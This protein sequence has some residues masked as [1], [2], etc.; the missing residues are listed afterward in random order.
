M[1]KAW[2]CA[3]MVGFGAGNARADKQLEG[4]QIHHGFALEVRLASRL[5][6]FSS[7][8][9]ALSIGA[10][11]GGIFA[12]Y[13]ISRVIFGLGFDISRVATGASGGGGADTS[14]A[15]TAFHF[16]P[17]VQVA[18][19]RSALKRVEMFG[20]FD[21]GF[22][23]TIHEQKPSVP[24]PDTS[25]FLL[26]YQVGP[27]VRYWP[28][29]QFAVSG[30]AGV[31]GDFSWVSTTPTGGGPTTKNSSGLTSIFAQLQMMGVF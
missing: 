13:K 3:A 23:T 5:F 15:D 14:A 28:H 25:T 20:E 22:G 6:S 2:V 10:L 4:E 29:P 12:G 16:T 30:L 7:G 21:I 18:I 27:G 8:T 31:E 11:Q 1:R 9:S 17:G 19:V 26:N 24:M